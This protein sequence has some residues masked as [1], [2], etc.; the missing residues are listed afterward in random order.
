LCETLASRVAPFGELPHDLV[1]LQQAAQKQCMQDSHVQEFETLRGLIEER[2]RELRSMALG[3]GAR[4]YAEKPSTFSS[5][6]GRYWHFWRRG[7]K[8]VR[9][10]TL[11]D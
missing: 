10:A 7:K 8:V 11:S 4:F 2:Q 9:R 1:L 5:R 6:L 3:L